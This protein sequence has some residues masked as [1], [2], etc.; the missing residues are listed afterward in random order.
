MNIFRKITWSTMRKNKVRT[1][2]TIVGVIL[3]AAMF[4]AVTTFCTSLLGFLE[5]TYTYEDGNYHVGLQDVDASMV[6]ELREDERTQLLLS[7]MTLGYAEEGSI[8]EDKPYLYVLAADEAFLKNMPVHII[9]GDIPRRSGELILP[10]HLSYNGGVKYSL[11]DTLR[12]SLG[13]RESEGFALTQSN[14]YI[15]DGEE[16]VDTKEDV[17][18]VVGFYER[19]DFEPFS[20]PGY[21]ALTWYDGIISQGENYDVY[22]KIK[23]AG[24]N[25]NPYLADHSIDTMNYELNGSVLQFSGVMRYNNIKAMIY[26]LV[27]AFLL[28]IFI[29]SVSLIYSAFSISVS[30]R[31]RQFGLLSSVGATRKQLG[32]SV[33]TE[34]LSV[35]GLGIPLGMLAGIG[36]M[37]VTLM[38]IGDKFHSLMV[39]P[40]DVELVVSWEAV[41]AAAA[42]SFV[43]VLVSA[44]IPSTR[45]MR[46]NAIDAIRQTRDINAKGKN[47]RV[48]G[49]FLRLFGVEGALARKYFKRSRKRYR[50]TV[51]SL[52]MSVML[53]ISASSYSMYL[54]AGTESG[55]GASNYDLEYGTYYTGMGEIVEAAQRIYPQV[56]E[57]SGVT[58]ASYSVTGTVY[59]IEGDNPTTAKYQEWR[60][61]S[62]DSDKLQGERCQLC[63]LDEASYRAFL[64]VNGL[65]ASEFLDVEK[66]AAILLNHVDSTE[67]FTEG[68]KQKRITYS[69]DYLEKG[70]EELTLIKTAEPLLGY[71]YMGMDWTGKAQGEGGLCY[72]YTAEEDWQDGKY[73]P[74]FEADGRCV[75]AVA[76]PVEAESIP[77]GALARYPVMGIDSARYP[78]IIY[79]VSALEEKSKLYFHLYLTSDDHQGTLTDMETLLDTEPVFESRYCN[80]IMEQEEDRNNILTLINVFSY[81]F[82]S[83]ISLIA[84]ANVFNTIST[85]VALRKRDFCMLQSI[86]MSQK[87]MMRMMNYECLLYGSRALLFGL[88]LAAVFTYFVFR[89]MEGGIEMSFTLPWPAVCIAVGSVFL[90]VFIT[91][92]YAMGKIKKENVV[93]ALKNENV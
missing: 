20:A 6:E 28:L 51:F 63:Y 73:V 36:G 87:G 3:S 74:G 82:I 70:A 55:Y 33:L 66:P 32:R 64:E 69:M 47:V 39:S 4:T 16:I 41:A 80:D 57:A 37:K 75:G 14:P 81:G 18:T 19:P 26:F 21:T 79:P 9:E 25:L 1:T 43:T 76:V 34:A 85:N 92:L 59:G 65:D 60:S 50:A 8:N 10:E 93:E 62:R 5:R 22:V 48:S 23:Q 91:M 31:T 11:G 44:W 84:V 56:L 53:F 86:G 12:L 15:P 45:A 90:V 78:S 27:I 88:P 13:S 71:R 30:E 2:V 77:I 67:Y 38:L 72:Y 40:Y 49:T 54:K 35:A 61:V 29:G 17:F 7:A 83:L 42:V 58:G 46:I 24:R 52:A 68:D 89:I